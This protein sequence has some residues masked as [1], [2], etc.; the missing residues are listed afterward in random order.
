MWPV[1]DWQT[2]WT[3][4][5]HCLKC[6]CGT[7]LDRRFSVVSAGQPALRWSVTGTLS[8]S[9]LD[10]TWLARFGSLPGISPFPRQGRRQCG[11]LYL[12]WL[13]HRLRSHNPHTSSASCRGS[14]W[15]G[16]G[17]RLPGASCRSR[18]VPWPRSLYSSHKCG[19]GV[20]VRSL[21]SSLWM[22]SWGA[23]GR[24]SQMPS[25]SDCGVQRRRY[26][27]HRIVDAVWRAKGGAPS[28]RRGLSTPWCWVCDRVQSG[29]RVRLGRRECIRL[30]SGRARGGHY[31]PRR[32]DSRSTPCLRLGDDG[33]LRWIH[34]SV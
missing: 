19:S 17:C 24:C 1:P 20:W 34:I 23:R 15:A 5:L 21:R 16:W 2:T 9:F 30:P 25:I 4:L 22:R 32:R 3:F 31:V 18:P 33:C 7:P 6:W 26:E 12:L 27:I 13:A 14:R 8:R 11:K 29:R 10:P 28:H